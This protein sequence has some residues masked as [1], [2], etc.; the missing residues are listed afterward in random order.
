MR[1][2][3]IYIIPKT[4]TDAPYHSLVLQEAKEALNK[5]DNDADILD[6]VLFHIGDMGRYQKL[7][8]LCMLPSGVF[9]AFLYFVQMF[10][11]VTPQQHW[12]RVPELAHLD[13]ELRLEEIFKSILEWRLLW[14]LALQATHST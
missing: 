1:L 14:Q 13:M 9:F 11:A 4:A 8:F 10:I 3:D 6:R 7:L 2:T 12:C 5:G